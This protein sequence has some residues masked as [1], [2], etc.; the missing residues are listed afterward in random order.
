[1]EAINNAVDSK[2]ETSVITDFML[3]PIRSSEMPAP[4][5]LEGM[6]LSVAFN[7]EGRIAVLHAATEEG[8]SF[9]T[10]WHVLANSPVVASEDWVRITIVQDYVTKRFQVRLH[11]LD[12]LT[13]IKGWNKGGD[14]RPGSWFHMVNRTDARMTIFEVHGDGYLDDL[15]IRAYL[16]EGSWMSIK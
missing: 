10:E 15:W 8:V 11:G 2:V 13:D 6:H 3:L 5:L 16:G 9:S 12:A 1:M 4:E 7:A 14:K